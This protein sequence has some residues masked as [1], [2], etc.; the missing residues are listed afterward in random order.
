LP[1]EAAGLDI[2]GSYLYVACSDAGLMI[3]DISDPLSPHVVA[4]T[5]VPGAYCQD[6]V[7][8]GTTA[9]VASVFTQ[10]Q[11]IDVS[12]P[13]SPRG[14]GY[15]PMFRSAW[16]I[17]ASGGN[18][19]VA[20]TSAEVIVLPTQCGS[21]PKPDR[22]GMRA[23]P[24]ALALRLLR[25]PSA[26]ELNLAFELPRPADVL[27]RLFDM[28]GREIARRTESIRSAGSQK[29]RWDV[30]GSR[31]AALPSGVYPVQVVTSIGRGEARWVVI[32]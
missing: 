6:V 17:A 32:R 29:I 28:Q 4:T 5:G 31:G 7:V 14:L 1:D 27:I 21:G 12:D 3:V 24:S 15:L 22:D 10:L 19:Y 30:A 11:V 8:D 13:T 26:R 23:A 9:Y 2:S 20:S 18:V 25:N 16:N